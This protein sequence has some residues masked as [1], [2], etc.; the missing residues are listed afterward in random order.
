MFEWLSPLGSALVTQCPLEEG[1]PGFVAGLAAV[2]PED[3]LCTSSGCLLGTGNTA[4]L[5]SILFLLS[6]ASERRL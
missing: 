5:C 2:C 1:T 3:Y 6:G 4:N